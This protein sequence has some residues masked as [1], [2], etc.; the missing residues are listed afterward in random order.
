MICP[1][2]PEESHNENDRMTSLSSNVMVCKLREEAEQARGDKE[3][4]GHKDEGEKQTA[5][6]LPKQDTDM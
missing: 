2:L 1:A 6:C 5:V 3:R 4:K